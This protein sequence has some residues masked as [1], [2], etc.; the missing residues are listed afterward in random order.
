MRYSD[1]QADEVRAIRDAIAKEHDHDVEKIAQAIKAREV[2][3]GRR[4]VCLPPREVAV[5]EGFVTTVPPR[6][7]AP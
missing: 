3:S 5:S 7:P 4:V 1:P 6:R 2:R